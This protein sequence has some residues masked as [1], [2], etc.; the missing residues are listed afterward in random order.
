MWICTF[1]F[2]CWVN[3]ETM[4][5]FTFSL[6]KDAWDL[7][8]SFMLSEQLIIWPLNAVQTLNSLVVCLPFNNTTAPHL[9]QGKHRLLLD[10]L[11]FATREDS[12]AS[13]PSARHSPLHTGC[14]LLDKLLVFWSFLSRLQS[15]HDIIL[16]HTLIDTKVFN[17]ILQKE[18]VLN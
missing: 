18:D 11:L 15:R 9:F 14:V 12:A 10:R 8:Y 17:I 4:C 3:A 1:P 5:A 16:F 13:L 2:S 6:K 7:F